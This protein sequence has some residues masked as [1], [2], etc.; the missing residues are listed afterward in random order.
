MQ[1]LIWLNERS[2][3]YFQKA[4]CSQG[5]NTLRQFLPHCEGFVADLQSFL[6]SDSLIKSVKVGDSLFICMFLT[7]LLSKWPAG[8][9]L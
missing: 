6:H 3:D 9:Q 5:W 8:K 7:Q 4:G 1:G 2:Y